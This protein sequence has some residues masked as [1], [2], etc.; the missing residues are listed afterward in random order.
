MLLALRHSRHRAAAF[1][2]CEIVGTLDESISGLTS[3]GSLA[4][5]PTHRRDRYRDRRKVSLPTCMAALV[6]RDSHPL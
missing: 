4:R 1:G 3:H 6:G 2:P 5:A